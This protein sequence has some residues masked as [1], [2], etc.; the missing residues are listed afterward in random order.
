MWILFFSDLNC[1][2]QHSNQDSFLSLCR[3][4]GK[5]LFWA[6]SLICLGLLEPSTSL[7][8][9][10]VTS[11]APAVRA[12]LSLTRRPGKRPLHLEYLPDFP[13]NPS[14]SCW[15]KTNPTPHWNSHD[16]RSR[17]RQEHL[18]LEA[19]LLPRSFL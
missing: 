11:S 7:I 12:S 14:R 16:S 19:Y 2:S 9:I 1:E 13:I 6:S 5:T 18:D 3:R 8:S 10:S 4:F 15:D 17:S